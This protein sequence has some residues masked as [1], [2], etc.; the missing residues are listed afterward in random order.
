MWITICLCPWFTASATC[1]RIR[2]S[3]SSWEHGA[4]V[5]KSAWI[6]EQRT[7]VT[8]VLYTFP[9]TCIRTISSA[10]RA[11]NLVLFSFTRKKLC[12]LPGM[13]VDNVTLRR[14]PYPR[15]VRVP[16]L[17]LLDLYTSQTIYTRWTG[18]SFLQMY[19]I[20]Q[21]QHI[22]GRLL[23]FLCLAS[24]LWMPN[25]VQKHQHRG[26][27]EVWTVLLGIVEVR[28]G[29]WAQLTILWEGGWLGLIFM[30]EKVLEVTITVLAC[31][32][33]AS[34][35]WT[36]LLQCCNLMVYFREIFLLRKQW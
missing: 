31:D 24:G 7:L 32:I 33:E 14:S 1:K 5:L 20:K 18:V 8:C 25:Q 29:S 10:S 22:P 36:I 30:F 21:Y 6:G 17:R 4:M 26:I 13:I 35:Q 28:L 2:E 34:K 23:M 15:L 9:S 27:N 12:Q 19:G 16:D 3:A 11:N